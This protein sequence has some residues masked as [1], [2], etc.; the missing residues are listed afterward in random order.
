VLKLCEKKVN[1]MGFRMMMNKR[2]VKFSWFGWRKI[3]NLE[4]HFGIVCLF[5]VQIFGL[6]EN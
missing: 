3:E 5:W 2:A 6:S 4:R 1:F